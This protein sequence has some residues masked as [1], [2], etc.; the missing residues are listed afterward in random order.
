MLSVDTIVCFYAMVQLV[1]CFVQVSTK[2]T[3]ISSP[4]AGGNIITFVLDSVLAY[5]LIAAGGA[6]AGS[7]YILAE[8]KVC[9]ALAGFCRKAEASIAMSFLAFA[10]LALSVAL[11][12]VRLLRMSKR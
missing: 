12:P 3:F 8:D 11:Y 5:S 4:T 1:L 9:D 2:G 7:Q 10:V 6:A